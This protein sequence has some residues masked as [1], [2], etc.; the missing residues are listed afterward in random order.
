M[1]ACTRASG[2]GHHLL[3]VVTEIAEQNRGGVAPRHPGDRSAR[4]SGSAGLVEAR[5]RHAMVREPGH[6]AVPPA[7]RQAAIVAVERAV[8]HVGV[9]AL[10]VRRAFYER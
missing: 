1:A 6:G 9:R 3:G 10:D 7:E 5:D 4:V 8:E 2:T